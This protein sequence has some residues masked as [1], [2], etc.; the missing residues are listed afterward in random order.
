MRYQHN[1]S[2]RHHFEKE[3]FT[4]K[5]D[6]THYSYQLKERGN[7]VIWISDNV[8]NS[9]FVADRIYGGANTPNFLVIM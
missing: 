8:V 2:H 7:I 5:K 1:E 9:W 4:P 6:W 3:S